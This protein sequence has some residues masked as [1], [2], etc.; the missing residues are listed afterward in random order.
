MVLTYTQAADLLSGM[1]AFHD[2]ARARQIAA[3]LR[4]K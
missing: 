1:G 2:A 4:S 3:E